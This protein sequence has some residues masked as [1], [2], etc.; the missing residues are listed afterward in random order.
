MAPP[1]DR[2]PN[3][4]RFPVL[5]YRGVDARQPVPALPFREHGWGGSWVNGVFDFHHFHST[6][7][8]A[9]AV[10]A[11][12]RRAGAR[13]AARRGISGVL[14]RRARPTGGTPVTAGRPHATASRSGP[15][16]AGRRTTT[17][18]AATTPR[19]SRPPRA[20]RRARGARSGSGRWRG[21]RGAG[22]AGRRGRRAGCARSA[23][24]PL[25]D[26]GDSDDHLD[27]LGDGHVGTHDAYLLSALRKVAGLEERP[28]AAT[29]KSG[30]S[31]SRS[32]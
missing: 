28:A 12:R 7:H 31:W 18:C 19:R 1:G 2:I 29:W 10:V 13:W 8:E 23:R 30:A 21:R 17:C 25:G 14:R 9:L 15:T 11:G 27:D 32:S 3:N 20:D 22:S 6:S 5:I 26:L 24:G 4:P 16:R